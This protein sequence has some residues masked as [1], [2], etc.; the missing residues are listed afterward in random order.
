MLGCYLPLACTLMCCAL[1]P[2]DLLTCRYAV[3]NT[4]CV[5]LAAVLLPCSGATTAALLLLR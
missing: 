3:L 1:P 2:S 5:A 4:M